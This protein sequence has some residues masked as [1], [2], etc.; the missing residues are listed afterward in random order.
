MAVDYVISISITSSHVT[1][2]KTRVSCN[3]NSFGT[4]AK[5]FNSTTKFNLRVGN[6]VNFR[7]HYLNTADT[8]KLRFINYATINLNWNLKLHASTIINRI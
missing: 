1:S 3:K 2:E 7:A 5:N 4:I 6:L 8:A